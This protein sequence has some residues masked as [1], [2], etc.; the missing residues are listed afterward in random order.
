MAM[1]SQRKRPG[2]LATALGDHLALNADRYGLGAD[3]LRLERIPGTAVEA[4]RSFTVYDHDRAVHVKLWPANRQGVWQQWLRVR[5]VLE[6]RY[7][8]PRII[9]VIDL[10]HISV[11]GLVFERIEGV[12]PVAGTSTSTLAAFAGRLHS[13]QELASNIRAFRGAATVGEFFERMHVRRGILKKCVNGQ[14]VYPL[15][16][17]DGL[18]AQ[19]R[20]Y[21]AYGKE[22]H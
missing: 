6:S 10:S 1:D 3:A 21:T 17:Q 22:K 11:S 8:A 4:M 15:S 7:Q 5:A 14:A 20:R 16:E 18:K 19:E 9:D 2:D 12:T 13:D